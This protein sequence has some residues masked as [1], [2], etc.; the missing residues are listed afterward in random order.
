MRRHKSLA[1][2]VESEEVR[3]WAAGILSQS[4]LPGSRMFRQ[5]TLDFLWPGTEEKQKPVWVETEILLLSEEIWDLAK[6]RKLP[7]VLA[8]S[9]LDDLKTLSEPRVLVALVGG[10]NH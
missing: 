10:K 8:G 2:A 7:P 3:K 1:W 4:P 6:I 9:P 5:E